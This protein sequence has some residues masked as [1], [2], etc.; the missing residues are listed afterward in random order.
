MPPKKTKVAKSLTLTVSC[1]SRGSGMTA[2]MELWQA[3]LGSDTHPKFLLFDRS[4]DGR[5]ASDVSTW[6]TGSGLTPAVL[7]SFAAAVTAQA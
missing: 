5:F 7:T 4:A 1:F 2:G 6:N 3:R